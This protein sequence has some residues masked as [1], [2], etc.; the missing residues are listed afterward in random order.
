MKK[1]AFVVVWMGELPDYFPLWF[2][3]CAKNETIDF[4]VF[5]D[6]SIKEYP[7]VENIYLV[8]MSFEEVRS[9]I[10]G[11]FDFPISLQKAYKLCDY[12]PTYGEAFSDYLGKYDFW[13]YCDVDLIWGDARKFLTEDILDE[14]DRIFTRGHCSLF[15]N[16]KEVNSY[17]RTLLP[18]GHLEYQEVFQSDQIWCFD[19]WGEHCGGGISVIFKEHGIP[20]YDLPVMGD[21]QYGKGSFFINRRDDLEK[22]DCFKYEDGK[23]YACN[24]NGNYELLYF[25]FQKRKPKVLKELA[26]C[27]F[28]F[29][30]PNLFVKNCSKYNYTL[31]S[32]L[33]VLWM[34]IK[35]FL[36]KLKKL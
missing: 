15:R 3:S 17:Y 32:R 1:I 36:R 34:D 26:A 30:P 24:R 33:I 35:S 29:I 22:I 8:N 7:N 14:Y 12:K 11:I 19:E 4:Y 6:S 16:T 27:D 21:I 2:A 13:G 5:T 20:T 31:K 23:A 18:K 25:H 10:Q 28:K 9:R